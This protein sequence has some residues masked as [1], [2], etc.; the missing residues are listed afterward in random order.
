MIIGKVAAQEALQMLLV[1][2][3][4]LIQALA[5]DTPNQTLDVGVLPWTLGSGQHFLDAQVP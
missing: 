1:Q 2:D 4:H 5:P 3:D